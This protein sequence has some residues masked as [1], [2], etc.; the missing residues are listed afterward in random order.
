MPPAALEGVDAVFHLAGEPVADGRWTASRKARILES[1]VEGTRAIVRGDPPRA[2]APRRARQRVGRRLVRVARR[3]RPRRVLPPGEGFLADVCR[4]WER[5][6]LAAE[7]LGVRVVARGTIGVVLARDGGAIAKM[8]PV[9]RAG[10][11]GPLGNGR[12]WMPWAHVGDVVGL[13]VH[14]ATT[15]SLRGPV[16]LCAPEP[17]RQRDFARALARAVHRPGV[18]P[19]PAF[20]LKLAF[21]EMAEVLLGSQ[22]VVPRVARE[23][24]YTSATPRSTAR[25]TTSWARRAAEPSVGARLA[26]IVQPF[27]R[28]I[29]PTLAPVARR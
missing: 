21:G 4:L 16:N 22:R 8:L 17:A 25:S 7:E 10:L 29:G 11:G 3:R 24:G 19:T 1:R 5:E 14:A 6:A 12:Q 9:F 23:A 26:V 28:A 18:V 15:P 13:L 20:A 27:A 2:A